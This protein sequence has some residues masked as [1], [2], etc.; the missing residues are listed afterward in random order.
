MQ[1]V[2]VALAATANPY[3]DEDSHLNVAR[4]QALN[5]LVGNAF[6]KAQDESAKPIRAV[7][8][9]VI[10]RKAK[11]AKFSSALNRKGDLK[12]LTQRALK[13]GVVK[14]MTERSSIRNMPLLAVYDAAIIGAPLAAKVKQ[15]VSA[16]NTH[17]KRADKTKT[18]VTK[19]KTKI[20]DEAN[21]TFEKSVDLIRKALTA[22]GVK[23]ADLVIGTSMFGKTMMV[24]LG[25]DNVI[26]IGKSDI[27][28]FRAAKKTAAGAE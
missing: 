10:S 23:D 26:S 4:I 3:L 18:S 20:R 7:Q 27:A 5:V 6:D 16:I 8:T 12:Y 22:G 25:A 15:A 19:V 21:A 28:K 24:K 1:K 13:I 2:I 17:L 14:R 11:P 9:F